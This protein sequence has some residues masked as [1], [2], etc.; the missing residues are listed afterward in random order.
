[1]KSLQGELWGFVP[2][3]HLPHRTTHPLLP[4]YDM[5]SLEV[6]D[7]VASKAGGPSLTGKVSMLFAK[8]FKKT[9]GSGGSARSRRDSLVSEFGDVCK[10]SIVAILS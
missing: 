10:N 2:K 3:H 9:T 8:R 1:M 4:C 7:S 6:D 5:P